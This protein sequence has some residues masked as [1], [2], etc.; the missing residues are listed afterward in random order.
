M[1]EVSDAIGNSFF[2]DSYEL[3]LKIVR[4]IENPFINIVKVSRKVKVAKE[5]IV[6][7]YADFCVY[8]Y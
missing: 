8:F 6:K 2:T 3:A 7:S 4:E 5:H 1:Y